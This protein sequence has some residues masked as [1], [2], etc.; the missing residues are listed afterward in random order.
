MDKQTSWFDDA[1]MA[2]SRRSNDLV[3]AAADLADK[4]GLSPADAVA[5]IARNVEGRSPQEVE[6]I[7]RNLRPLGNNRALV[8]AG[9]AANEAR[10]RQAGGRGARAPEDVVAPVRLSA[11]AYKPR[12][13][14]AAVRRQVPVAAQAT[15]DYFRDNTPIAIAQDVGDLASAGFEAFKRDPFGSLVETAVYANPITAVAAAP[16]D[17]AAMREGSQML[18]PYVKDDAEAARAQQMV[19]ALSALPAVAVAPGVG[20]AA[21]KKMRKKAG[22]LAVKRKS[23]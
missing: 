16:F 11:A 8:E 4:Y 7:R 5:W 6:R 2:V 3:A 12:A 20:I 14:P 21:R 1:L 9:A 23:R 19:D 22:G 13:I 17:Y 10:F 15:A 18:E